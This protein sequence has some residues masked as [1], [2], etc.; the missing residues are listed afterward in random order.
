[1]SKVGVDAA[2]VEAEAEA[3][4]NGGGGGHDLQ[5]PTATNNLPIYTNYIYYN[6][7]WMNVF[8]LSSILKLLPK[9]AMSFSLYRYRK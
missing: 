3:G 4:R 1:M 7:S 5:S 6:I 9:S 2:V 8:L